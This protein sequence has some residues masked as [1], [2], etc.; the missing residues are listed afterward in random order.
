MEGHKYRGTGING[1]SRRSYCYLLLP[2]S[3][4]AEEPSPCIRL[5]SRAGKRQRLSISRSVGRT[6]GVA[7]ANPFRPTRFARWLGSLHEGH[8]RIRGLAGEASLGYMTLGTNAARHGLSFG[9]SVS[10]LASGLLQSLA[11]FPSF[12]KT[13]FCT[14]C[15]CRVCLRDIRGLHYHECFRCNSFVDAYY[16]YR[17]RQSLALP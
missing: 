6:R 4:A 5:G 12:R 9:E 8:A 11:P 13:L 16:R 3:L 14:R 15:E 17:K 7:G 2:G 10:P 1:S